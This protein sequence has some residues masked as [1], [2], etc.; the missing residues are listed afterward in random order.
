M[1]TTYLFEVSFWGEDGKRDYMDMRG[2]DK[3]EVKKE[4]RE[5]FPKLIF[6]HCSVKGN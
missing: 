2:E 6:S 4:F 5:K 1:K 3:N